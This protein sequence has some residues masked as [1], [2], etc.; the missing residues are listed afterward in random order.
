[1]GDIIAGTVTLLGTARSALIY[2]VRMIDKRRRAKQRGDDAAASGMKSVVPH[3]R[4]GDR[5]A[6]RFSDL[7]CPG[8]LH[9]C[10]RATTLRGRV[11]SRL[12][13]RS[14]SMG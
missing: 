12:A 13:S 7:V 11:G 14:R 6:R 5:C 10:D 1:M 3:C 4:S 8:S 9:A 2:L